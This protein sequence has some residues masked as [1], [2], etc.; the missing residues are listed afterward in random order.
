NRYCPYFPYYYYFPRPYYYHHN[1]PTC[2]L[3]DPSQHSCCN[4]NVF[5]KFGPYD[6]CCNT[7]RYDR[8]YYIC[9]NGQVRK[10]VSA[11]TTTCCGTE[12]YNYRENTC[13]YNQVLRITD[14]KR[15]CCGYELYNYKTHKCCNG[16]VVPGGN[17]HICCGN[18]AW[19]GTLYGCCGNEPFYKPRWS[20]CN[21]MK[22]S[23]GGNDA[24]C[25]GLKTFNRNTHMCC[26]RCIHPKQSSY[27]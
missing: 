16:I 7:A 1:Y 5:D 25:C 17:N 15:S 27:Q 8:R 21:G 11:T 18:R 3:I 9:C 4:G 14:D 12:P 6:R 19:D 23:G 13:C 10:R 2:R 24:R 22:V 26:C 20:C